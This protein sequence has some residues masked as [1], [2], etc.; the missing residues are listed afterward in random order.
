MPVKPTSPLLG[1]E[2]VLL[3][4]EA[5]SSL[6]AVSERLVQDALDRLLGPHFATSVELLAHRFS[7]HL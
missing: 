7:R 2:E 1:C 6:D 3:L 5:T 4:D